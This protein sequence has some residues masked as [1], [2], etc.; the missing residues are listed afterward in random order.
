MIDQRFNNEHEREFQTY[1]D[2]V[3]ADHGGSMVIGPD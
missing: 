1:D 2:G 3:S